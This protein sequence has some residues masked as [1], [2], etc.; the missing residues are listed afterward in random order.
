[1]R[2]PRYGGGARAFFETDDLLLL[3]RDDRWPALIPV[4]TDLC[5]RMRGVTF[6]DLYRLVGEWPCR[7]P[8]RGIRPLS[9]PC[10]FT[11]AGCR[12][13]VQMVGALQGSG[14][15]EPCWRLWE[16]RSGADATPI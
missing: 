15:V 3:P 7:L 12:W 1:M 11:D 6:E 14:V 16:G 8:H 5:H 4:E 9:L 10:G 13:G 2:G